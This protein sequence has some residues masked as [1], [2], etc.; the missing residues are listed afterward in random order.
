MKRFFSTLI[1]SFLILVLSFCGK[2]GPIY[3]PHIKV[4]QKI[5]TVGIIQRG[6]KIILE[7]ANPTT[8]EDGSPLP[9]VDEIEVWLYEEERRPAGER[10][11]V[12]IEGFIKKAKIIT[13]I[14]QRLFPWYKKWKGQESPEFCYF[15]DLADEDLRLKR[16][17]FSLRIKYRKRKEAAF[18]DLLSIE[19]RILPLSPRRARASL[20]EDR[21]LLKWDPPQRN[22]NQTW[23]PIVSGY[24]IYRID[25]EGQPQLLNTESLIRRSTFDDKDIIFD[26][27]YR[28]F[29]RAS[30]NLKPPYLESDDSE[31]IEITPRDVFPPAAP[32]GL[33]SVAG[34]NFIS[35]SWS[36]NRE[37]DLAGYRVWRK[38]EEGDEYILLTL[39][40]IRENTYTDTT[41]E[42]DKRYYYAITTRDINGNESQRSEPISEIIKDEIL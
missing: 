26:N 23:P 14:N 3:P 28:Y 20:L 25:K 16:L 7:W 27:A 35:I 17:I 24:N 37:A 10:G 42:K 40:P 33:M 34:E 29:I 12:G 9:E 31:L 30:A 36:E 13:V 41:V 32:T 1:A 2:K 38:T 8:Y 18:S 39:D 6:D 11:P 4:A 19:P 21:V 22:I 5:K 15:Y